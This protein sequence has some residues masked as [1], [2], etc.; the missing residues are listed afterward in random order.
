MFFFEKKNQKTFARL[1]PG[2][3]EPCCARCGGRRSKSYLFPFFKK[4]DV[5]FFQ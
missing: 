2:R 3:A 4:E 5:Y 1:H